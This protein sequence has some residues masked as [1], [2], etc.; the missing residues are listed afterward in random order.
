MINLE[1]LCAHF[2]RLLAQSNQ[3]LVPLHWSGLGEVPEFIAAI[4]RV[5]THLGAGGGPLTLGSSAPLPEQATRPS[6]WGARSPLLRIT[7]IGPGL[8]VCP[9]G[10]KF[11]CHHEHRRDSTFRRGL[12]NSEL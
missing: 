2:R 9:S 7:A 4:R 10:G 5:D 6:V 3:F 1:D 8:P 12:G 11:V